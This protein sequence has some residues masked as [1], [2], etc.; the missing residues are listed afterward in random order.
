MAKSKKPA[1]KAKKPAPKPLKKAQKK[2]AKPVAKPKVDPVAT[3][4]K[5]AAEAAAQARAAEK[6]AAQLESQRK[7]D[8]ERAERELAQL[9][10]ALEK[11]RQKVEA[12]QQAIAAQ[13]EAARQAEL[14]RKELEKN[15]ERERREAEK[16]AEQERKA[17]E[18]AEQQRLKAEAKA[19]ED[20]AKAAAKLAAKKKP[21][22]MSSL[23]AA[24]IFRPLTEERPELAPLPPPA[25]PG[26]VDHQMLSAI[27]Y[28]L[29][30]AVNKTFG[31]AGQSVVKN[32]SLRILEY[33][34]KRGWLPPKAKE[35]VRALNE[36]FNRL[37]TMG[38]AER[39]HVAKRGEN[40][41]L[42]VHGL[43]DFE[44]VHE[45]RG[46]HYPLLPVFLGA[47]LEAIVDQ[48]FSLKATM[49]PIEWQEN[50]RGFNLPFSIHERT[51]APEVSRLPAMSRVDDFEE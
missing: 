38:Y 23:A 1:G 44:A 7:K 14:S 51:V 41:V 28:G 12:A 50:K 16:R 8:A 4:R 3:A 39:I 48:Y 40:Y 22:P 32:A 11:E 33:G 45:L 2:P 49:E 17:A 21:I 5:A 29:F 18:K 24:P 47:M 42:E 46:M 27:E 36:F 25:K 15:V 26:H 43:A 19:A 9:R 35:P 13:K 30:A 10:Q 31:F 20:A 37:E 34:Y 6:L